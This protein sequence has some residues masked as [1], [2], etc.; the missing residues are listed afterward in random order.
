MKQLFVLGVALLALS[1][2]GCATRGYARR[3]AAKVNDQATQVETQLTALT[4]KHD[5]DLAA[6]Q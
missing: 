4:A 3:Q 1:A 6:F 5:T 2:A